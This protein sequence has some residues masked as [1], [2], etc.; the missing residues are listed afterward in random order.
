MNV[1]I[2]TDISQLK[3]SN[4]L[5]QQALSSKQRKQIGIEFMLL[6]V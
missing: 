5:L 3:I 1:A 2:V 6:N 4:I